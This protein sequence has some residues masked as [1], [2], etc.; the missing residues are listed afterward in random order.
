MLLFMITLPVQFIALTL[1]GWVN[2][3]QQDVIEYLHE[4]NRVLRE[5]LGGKRLRFTNGQ[6]RRV[7]AKAK[8]VGRKGLFEIETLVT[9]DT[10]LRWYRGLI[11]RK[12]DGSKARRPVAPRQRPISSN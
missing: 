9:P 12:Y 8:T 6:R 2:R 7:A 4:E 5:Q 11:A 3:S 1:A 10:L